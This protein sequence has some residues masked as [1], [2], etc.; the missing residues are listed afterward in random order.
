M[1][2]KLHKLRIA[3]S[4]VCEIICLLLIVLWVRSYRLNEVL[5]R[6]DPG[7]QVTTLGSNNGDCYLVRMIALPLNLGPPQPPRV[8][9]DWKYDSVRAPDNDRRSFKFTRVPNGFSLYLPFGS[10]LLC[11]LHSE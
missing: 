3:F 5:F 9:N 11:L 8:P 10:L 2:N 1:S 4:I 6:L 7:N